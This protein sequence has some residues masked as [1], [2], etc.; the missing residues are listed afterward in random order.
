MGR[1]LKLKR[2]IA[3]MLVFVLMFTGIQWNFVVSAAGEEPYIKK[4]LTEYRSEYTKTYL[5]SNGELESVVSS[6]ALHFRNEKGEWEE[7]DQ[8]LVLKEKDGIEVY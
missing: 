1:A 3:S 2:F 6:H 5:K 8:S 7:I 4:E